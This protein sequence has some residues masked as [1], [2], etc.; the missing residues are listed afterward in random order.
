MEL[1]DQNQRYRSTSAAGDPI[2][3]R[4]FFDVLAGR[5]TAQLVAF[6]GVVGGTIDAHART[7]LHSGGI[8]LR[9]NQ[10]CQAQSC[11]GG[12]RGCGQTNSGCLG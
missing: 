9:L 5:E 7:E 2:I 10:C 6:P 3:A 12:C 4:P 11:C 8:R 1:C